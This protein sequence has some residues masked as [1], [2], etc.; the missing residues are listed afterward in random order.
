MTVINGRFDLN[1]KI[2]IVKCKLEKNR[3][4]MLAIRHKITIPLYDL[5]CI[6]IQE[7]REKPYFRP[8]IF[9]ILH[10]NNRNMEFG[11]GFAMTTRR[12]HKVN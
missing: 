2:Q 5:S 3:R 7:D 6:G 12:C 11:I 4:I 10:N 9:Q 1:R 8:R